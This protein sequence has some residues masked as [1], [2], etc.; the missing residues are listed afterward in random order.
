MRADGDRDGD[1]NAS[2]YRRTRGAMMVRELEQI[3]TD[4]K[5]TRAYAI[6]QQIS[7]QRG[8]QIGL[9]ADRTIVNR[10]FGL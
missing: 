9:R 6:R 2:E 5:H 3:G 7:D 4:E 10:M 1:R 8:W